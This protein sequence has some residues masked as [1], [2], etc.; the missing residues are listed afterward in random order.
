[1]HIDYSFDESIRQR[2]FCIH[3]FVASFVLSLSLFANYF[4]KSFSS[5]RDTHKST[6]SHVVY[7]I[8]A[9]FYVRAVCSPRSVHGFFGC[10]FDPK[11]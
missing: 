11:K 5:R 3:H 2:E 7:F 1:M 8:F 4:D 6:V 9:R 10:K